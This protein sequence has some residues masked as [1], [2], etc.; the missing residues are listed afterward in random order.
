MPGKGIKRGA[1]RLSVT[2]TD[3][4]LNEARWPDDKR[5]P[6]MQRRETRIVRTRRLVFSVM[7]FAVALTTVGT[8]ANGQGTYDITAGLW[9]PFLP[10]YTAGSIVSGGVPQQTEIFNEDQNGVGGQIGFKGFYH[11]APTRTML[12]FDLNFAGADKIAS[13][14]QTFDDPGATSAV[15]F[16]SSGGSLFTASQDGGTGTIS[17]DGDVIHHSQYIGLRDRFDLCDWGI[18]VFDVGC[19]FSHLAFDQDYTLTGQFG[20]TLA[21]IHEDLDNE[22]VGGEVRSTLIRQIGRHPVML[23]VDFGLYDLD[24]TYKATSSFPGGSDQANVKLKKTAFTLDLG[25][26]METKIR[27]CTIKPG[28]NLKY[29]SDM[30]TIIH[31]PNVEAPVEPATL[32]TEAGY[33]LGLNVELQL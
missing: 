22:Y 33:F 21:T 6:I 27:G 2:S 29:I 14:Q 10:D 4:P 17:V 13:G 3:P 5:E 26:R 16:A 32:S 20:S 11:F 19:G 12:E 30:A 15:W 31:A 25:L 1:V 9:I 8:D 7:T 24:G 23:D 28:I 18:G